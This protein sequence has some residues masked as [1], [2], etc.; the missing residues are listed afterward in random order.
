MAA[1]PLHGGVSKHVRDLSGRLRARGHAVTVACPRRSLTWAAL[2]DD[3]AI[4]LMPIGGH[5]RPVPGDL[6]GAARLWRL[7]SAVDVVHAHSAKAGALARMAVALRNQSAPCVFTPHGWSFWAVGEPEKT[8][9]RRFERWAAHRSSAIIALSNHERE[10]GLAAGVGRPAQYRVIPN[11]VD[12]ER[13]AQAPTTKPGRLVLVTRFAPP[14]RTDLVLQAM[15][16]LARD[17]REV[18]L[19][20]VGDGP[21]RPR[22]ERLARELG[23]VD[24]VSFLGARSDMPDLL[25]GAQVALLASD[26]EGCPLVLLE[27][28]AAGVPVLATSVGGVPEIIED[29]RTGRL[30]EAGS[31]KAFAHALGE[32]LDQP[33]TLRR[34]GEEG[35]RQARLRF[36]QVQMVARIEDL[37]EE[38]IAAKRPPTA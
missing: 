8:V 11:G 12:I 22:L 21:D 17:S 26:Y 3:P 13:F 18:D 19:Q 2:E 33:E 23:V 14:K 24:R 34:W 4:S 35:R 16:L 37:Y 31:A 10:A 28:M 38:V 32:M 15:R 6:P 5:R 9:Y 7:A 29:G 30:V 27:A 25:A 20:I 36:S 1:Q